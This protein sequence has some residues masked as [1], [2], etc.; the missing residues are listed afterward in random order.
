MTLLPLI[1]LATTSTLP[2]NPDISVQLATRQQVIAAALGNELRTHTLLRDIAVMTRS[3]GTDHT[4]YI[5]T[6]KVPPVAAHELPPLAFVIRA[7]TKS[8]GQS[9]LTIF[10]GGAVTRS[11]SKGGHA[12]LAKAIQAAMTSDELT[13]ITRNDFLM[14]AWRRG[15]DSAGLRLCPLARR[16][17]VAL[18]VTW[19]GKIRRWTYA[20]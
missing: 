19:A 5:C 13:S 8:E 14:Y 2:K 17:S 9:T 15:T 11:I 1:A 16:E 4:V 20:Y 10:E 18:D 6:A 3:N 12:Q 7:Y